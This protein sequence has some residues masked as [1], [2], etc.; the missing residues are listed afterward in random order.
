[1]VHLWSLDLAPADIAARRR[2]SASVLQLVRALASRA[3]AARQARLWLVATTD[4]QLV[5]VQSRMVA[6]RGA[7]EGEGTR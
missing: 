2:A 3:P 6:A 7:G 1:I 4:D 5:A